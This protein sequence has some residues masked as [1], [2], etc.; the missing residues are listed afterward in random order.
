MLATTKISLAALAVMTATT[1][2]TVGPEV[3]SPADE[4]ASAVASLSDADR[5]QI[6]DRCWKLANQPNREFVSAGLCVRAHSR[7]ALAGEASYASHS[8]IA[9]R[10]HLHAKGS[11]SP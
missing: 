9:Y 5:D 6:I 11:D 1:V 2:V 7:Q 4:D 3:L 8:L 10:D